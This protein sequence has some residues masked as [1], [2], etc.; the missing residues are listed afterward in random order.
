M[1]HNKA[2]FSATN[3]RLERHQTLESLVLQSAGLG[4]FG[5]GE[6]AILEKYRARLLQFGRVGDVVNFDNVN[7]FLRKN[8]NGL[9]LVG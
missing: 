1:S 3:D 4:G 6:R 7:L 5:E 2:K 9:K 8:W